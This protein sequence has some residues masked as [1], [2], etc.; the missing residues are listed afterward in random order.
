MVIRRKAKR[1]FNRDGQDRQDKAR[2]KVECGMKAKLLVIYPSAFI[3]PPSSF[4]LYP[5]YPVHPV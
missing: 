3:I 1:R 5:A 2:Q 4:L